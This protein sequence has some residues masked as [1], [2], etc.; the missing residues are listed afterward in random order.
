M[1]TQIFRPVFFFADKINNAW[2]CK[3]IWGQNCSSLQLWPVSIVSGTKF[4]VWLIKEQG[5][6]VRNIA[7]TEATFFSAR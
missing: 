1:L 5:E 3:V 4:G 2:H 6:T 7:F